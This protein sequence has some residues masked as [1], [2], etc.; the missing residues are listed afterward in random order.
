MV[1]HGN[2]ALGSFK[3]SLQACKLFGF[4][5]VLLGNCLVLVQGTR[6]L[7]VAV[8]VVILD[9][10]REQLI[11]GDLVLVIDVDGCV[12]GLLLLC[13]SVLW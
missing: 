9:E 4:E 10:M 7:G 5:I 13:Q 11:D 12:L 3:L 2:L 8:E 6:W 1:H